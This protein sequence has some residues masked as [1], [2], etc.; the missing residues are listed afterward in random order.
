MEKILNFHGSCVAGKKRAS[1]KGTSEWNL[2]GISYNFH[3]PLFHVCRWSL[4]KRDFD[5]ER[6]LVYCVG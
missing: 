2:I 1:V 4:K 5:E 3:N 6:L